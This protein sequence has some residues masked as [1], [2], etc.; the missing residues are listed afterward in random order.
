MYVCG[1]QTIRLAL[2]HGSGIPAI[3]AA[4]KQ[5]AIHTRIIIRYDFNNIIIIII[6]WLTI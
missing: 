5:K 4:E 6:H 2:E 1:W 3:A